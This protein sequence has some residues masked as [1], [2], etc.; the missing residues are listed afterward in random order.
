MATSSVGRRILLIRHAESLKNVNGSHSSIHGS[1][2][3]VH[4]AM[5]DIS[6]FRPHLLQ[7][8][9]PY[10]PEE[11]MAVTSPTRRCID[12]ARILLP[13][14][15]IVSDPD[16]SP[17]RSPY[18]ELSEEDIR[19]LDPAFA[20]SLREYRTGLISAYSID[21]RGG[22]FVE[23][24]ESRVQSVLDWVKRD[25]HPVRIIIGHRSTLTA[26]LIS[27]SREALTY[28]SGWYGHISVPI[29]SLWLVVSAENGTGSPPRL[30]SSTIDPREVWR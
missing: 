29:L 4:S 8:A 13:D 10:G 5:E 7:A 22:E 27:L 23:A 26:A 15:R 6:V 14:V 2:P 30:L 1:E 11:W 21:R 16:L 28:P 3:L 12:T 20:R 24:F 25:R 19:V 18:P 9:L 17:I